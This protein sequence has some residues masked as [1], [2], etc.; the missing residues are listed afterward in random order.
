M[1][2]ENAIREKNLKSEFLRNMSH[3]IRTPMNSILSYSQMLRD[4]NFSLEQ[5]KEFVENINFSGKHLMSL[6]DDVLNYAKTESGRE[7]RF[8]SIKLRPILRKI[9]ASL[10]PLAAE[11]NTTLSLKVP[12]DTLLIALSNPTILRQIIY[13]L[14]SNAIKFTKDG[15]IEITLQKSQDGNHIELRIKDTGIGMSD[16]FKE[17]L[18]T[19][20]SQEDS[21]SIR[22]YTGVGIGLALS[23]KLANDLG[24]I[25]LLEESTLNKGSTFLLK[26]PLHTEK[27]LLDDNKASTQKADTK[28]QN[29][30]I[31]VA[32]DSIENFRI[33]KLFLSQPTIEIEWAKNGKEAIEKVEKNTYDI[34]LMDVQMPILDGYSATRA[35][36]AKYPDLPIVALTAHALPEEFQSSMDAGCDDHLTKPVDKEELFQVINYLT[37]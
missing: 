32:E 15:S 6:I 3:E 31:L 1:D 14:V 16:S 29:I 35:I 27:S 11:S 12:Q 13:N 8:V 21:S 10:L 22:K 7:L 2:R 18:F 4:E 23:K 28:L 19:P 5:K 17:K 30:S 26:L 20:F 34:I 37:Q 24:G 9:I 33:L 25:L 36:K